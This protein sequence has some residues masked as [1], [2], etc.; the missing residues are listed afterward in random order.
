MIHQIGGYG[1]DSNIYLI[2]DEQIALIDTGTGQNSDLVMQNLTRLGV[3]TREI[4]LIINTHCHYDHIGGNRAFIEAAGCEV[5]IHELDAEP[6][7]K[8]DPTVTIARN[9]GVK[10]EPLK[11]LRELREGDRIELGALTLEVLHTPGH[12]R[13]S[14]C[15]YERKQKA[16]FSGDTV[17]CDGIGR[18]DLPTSDRAAMASSLRRLAELDVEKLFP[19]HGPIEEKSAHKHLELALKL[20][21]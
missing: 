6:L 14:I 9:F 11:P 20:I 1:F 5:A 7:R 2:K 3:R 12:T 8:A 16:L 21:E 13:G 15:L 19:G 4:N 17:F 18:T 10:L